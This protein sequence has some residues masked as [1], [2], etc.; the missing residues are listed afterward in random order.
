MRRLTLA[1]GAALLAG[2][3]SAPVAYDP[4]KLDAEQL[5]VMVRDK[6]A[7]VSCVRAVYLTGSI[8]TIFINADMAR[9]D[10][11]ANVDGTNCSAG[12]GIAA[13]ASA[14]SVGSK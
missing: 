1:A 11:T 10:G 9:L 3:M 13:P 6:S 5:K 7:T 12:V 8:T 4:S 2:C 14:A